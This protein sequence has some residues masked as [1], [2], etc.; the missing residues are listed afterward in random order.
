[1][2]DSALISKW[3]DHHHLRT[4]L[5]HETDLTVRRPS[6]L[7]YDYGKPTIQTKIRGARGRHLTV[8]GFST[9]GLISY[10]LK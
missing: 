6:G 8:V 5:R 3:K 1:M 2:R 4:W 7:S 10:T 9:E